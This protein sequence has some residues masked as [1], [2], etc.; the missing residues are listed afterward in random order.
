MLQPVLSIDTGASQT[1][2]DMTLGIGAA[3]INLA[4]PTVRED[5][6]VRPASD[7]TIDFTRFLGARAVSITL[8]LMPVYTTNETLDDIMARF[9]PFLQPDTPVTLT[10]TM[11]TS[12]GTPVRRSIRMRVSD[13]QAPLKSSW[14]RDLQLHWVAADPNVYDINEDWYRMLPMAQLLGPGRVYSLTY[15]RRYTVT[16][17]TNSGIQIQNGG[18]R[19]T[20]PIIEFYG[21]MGDGVSPTSFAYSMVLPNGTTVGG[22]IQFLPTFTFGSSE[23]VTV[24]TRL[25]SVTLDGTLNRFSSLDMPNTVWAPLLPSTNF[26]D[27]TTMFYT[28]TLLAA[29]TNAYSGPGL[30]G[31][32]PARPLPAAEVGWSHV[33]VSYHDAYLL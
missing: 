10:Y 23:W 33:V 17:P 8:H 11:A 26:A 15:P 1:V 9:A 3:E 25:R 2:D 4:Y 6:S 21:P 12:H 24:D 29:S 7:G 20:W 31:P 32:A 14:N 27:P 18:T 22:K 28:S 5:M 30:S 19:A 16:T 13:F